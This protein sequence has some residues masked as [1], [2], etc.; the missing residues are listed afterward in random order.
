MSSNFKSN[1]SNGEN[2][3]PTSVKKQLW[4]K[5]YLVH[6]EFD[7]VYYY[8]DK[9][10]KSPFG[11]EYDFWYYN[12]TDKVQA[13]LTNEL[14]IKLTNYINRKKKLYKILGKID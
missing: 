7:G 14:A 13:R 11:F 6:F 2:I 9:R 5:S 4:E 12:G 8:I 3:I 1:I 10:Y